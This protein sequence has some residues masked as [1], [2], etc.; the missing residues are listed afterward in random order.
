MTQ[1]IDAYDVTTTPKK[2]RPWLLPLVVGVIALLVGIGIGGSGS[3]AA[4][5]AAK[6][7][8]A[9]T[10]TVTAKPEVKTE[11]VNKE[12][13]V[14]K[15]PQACLDALGD[16]ESLALVASDMSQ[17]VGRHMASDGKLFNQFADGDMLNV[18]WYLTD[19]TT[20]QNEIND[21]TTRVQGNNFTTNAAA[22]RAA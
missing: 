17:S 14:A 18:E 19:Q 21:L 3:S 2:R 6:P 20:F 12:V 7:A 1:P 5:E 10:V 11:T 16:A 9:P 4:P 13:E 15:T 22:C 8:P